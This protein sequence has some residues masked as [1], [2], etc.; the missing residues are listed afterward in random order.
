GRGR[1]LV[2]GDSIVA[3]GEDPERH[4]LLREMRVR[5]LVGLTLRE[6]LERG[7]RVVDLV[8]V[9]VARPVQ[10][11]AAGPEHRERDERRDGHVA[12]GRGPAGPEPGGSDPPPLPRGTVDRDGPA[13]LIPEPGRS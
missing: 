2:S 6:E 4:D 9:H 10:A 12:T 8:E 13:R 5:P 1:T 7:T 11:I 3:E